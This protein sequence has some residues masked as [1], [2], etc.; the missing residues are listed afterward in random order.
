MNKHELGEFKKALVNLREDIV[1]D[2]NHIDN[3]TLKQSQRDASGDLSG[4][5]FH[6][7]DMATDHYDREFSLGL[8]SSGRKALLLIDEA[9]K[10]IKDGT[11]GRCLSCNKKIKKIRL[12]ALPYA[13]H[14]IGAR[15]KKSDI[16]RLL[17]NKC[18]SPPYPYL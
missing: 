5:S 3:D 11:F 16:K 13:Q 10:R 8:A 17:Y 12:R 1:G 4:Y 6:M 15:P 2:V 18:S 14:C 7:A 9:L